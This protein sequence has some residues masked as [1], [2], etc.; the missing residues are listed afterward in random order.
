M[1]HGG[2][3][4][5]MRGQ[6]AVIKMGLKLC[7]EPID[8]GTAGPSWGKPPTRRQKGTS[9]AAVSM[10]GSNEQKRHIELLV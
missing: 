3:D 7:A 4:G 6:E 2:R 10:K 9:P 1:G 8:M 5:G